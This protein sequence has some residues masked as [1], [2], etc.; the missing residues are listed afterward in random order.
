MWEKKERVLIFSSREICYMSSNFFANQVGDAFEQLGFAADV[1]EFTKDDDFDAKLEPFIG[2]E[3]RVVLDFNSM[4]PR[5]VMEDEEPY[6]KKLNGPFFDYILDHP[7]FHYTGITRGGK[8][9]HALVLDEAQEQYVRQYYPKTASV[10][11]LPLGATRALYDG[12][13][14]KECRILFPGTYDSPDAVYEMVQLAPE[15]IR[16]IMKDIIERRLAEPLISME[17]AFRQ[18]LAEQEMEIPVEQFALFMNAMY[19]GDAYIRDYFRKAALDELLSQG[20]PVTVMGEGWEK[21]H[22]K[23]EHS[24]RR[25][26]GVPFALSFERIAKSHILLN[27][28]PIFNRGMHDR[29]P[30]GMANRA[31]VL[32]DKNPY[33]ETRFTDGRELA[34][35]SLSDL[36]T[37][38]RWAERLIGDAQ[39]RQEMAANAEKE[40]LEH[41]TWVCRARQILEIADRLR[42]CS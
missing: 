41:H 30:A 1:C 31:V 7:L 25:E 13:K 6:I 23:D 2:Q 10:H 4:L 24:L 3:Y 40:F 33:L 9:L 29:I 17:E 14:E 15:P 12:E 39:L 42:S 38:S 5:M 18:Y 16:S 34:F 37:L 32:T 36:S 28:S 27:V 19:S 22:Y 21:Y 8:N 26:P 20:I 11:T 35:Y